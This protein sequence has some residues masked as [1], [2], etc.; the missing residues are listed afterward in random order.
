MHGEGR[1]RCQLQLWD[2]LAHIPRDERDS[3]LHCGYNRRG[4]RDAISTRMAAACLLGKG[5]D[6]VALGVEISGNALAI[7]PPPALQV[8]KVIR[9]AD[10]AYPLGDR[11]A[12]P[13]EAVVCL[14]SRADV[15]LHLG[16]LRCRLCGTTWTTFF[17]RAGGA[18]ETRLDLAER[19][20]RLHEDF[21]GSAQFGSHGH[22]ARL[23]PFMLHMAKVR[24]VRRPQ[25]M[26]NRG[27]K[28][29]SLITCR[30][31][32]P[33]IAPRKGLR[34]AGLPGVVLAC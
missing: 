22:C 8:H 15:L 17:T 4:V 26:C 9:G 21:C 13:G 1:R 19:F 14:T 24:R 2:L 5:A 31:D 6:R 16:Q 23:A 18:L 29:R 7:A 27:Q 12:L 30:L 34:H 33:T 3:R 25:V 28:P 32:D 11:L 20:F 10:G